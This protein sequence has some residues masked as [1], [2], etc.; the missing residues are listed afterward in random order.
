METIGKKRRVSGAAGVWIV[1]VLFF[2]IFSYL[3][4]KTCDDWLFT[5]RLTHAADYGGLFGA[6]K[7]EFDTWNGRVLGN[8]LSVLLSGSKLLRTLFKSLVYAAIFHAMGTLSG[9][10]RRG[11]LGW[12]CVFLC[13]FLVPAELRNQTYA[14]DAGFINYAGSMA[15]ILCYLLLMQ[16]LFAGNRVRDSVWTMAA[17]LALGAASALFVE[18]VTA[19]A[20]VLGCGAAVWHWVRFRR[21]SF[22]TVCFLLGALAGTALMLSSP[23][24]AAAKH[25]AENAY[26]ALPTDLPTLLARLKTNYQAFSCYSLGAYLF[27]HLILSG[28]SLWLL[29]RAD[30][31]VCVIGKRLKRA[32]SVLLCV[33]P[34][35]FHLIAREFDYL[36]MRSEAFDT[37][38]RIAGSFY[39]IMA[40]DLLLYGLY[41]LS[42]AVVFLFFVPDSS[43]KRLGLLCVVSAVTVGGPM[44]FV[45]PTDYRCFFPSYLFWACAALLLIRATIVNFEE[46]REARFV[47]PVTA[48]VYAVM[49][50]V[51]AWN[52]TIYADCPKLEQARVNYL[53]QQMSIE[54]EIIVLPEFNCERSL[55]YPTV[56]LGSMFYYH[57]PNDIEMPFIPYADWKEEFSFG[58]SEEELA[59]YRAA[60]PNGS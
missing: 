19:Y 30:A 48:C 25:A 43:A 22:C 44:L 33:L 3:I 27:L 28:A 32:L 15:L 49:A 51:C 57:T 41:V 55:H 11:G 4:P 17:C 34:V 20:L 7:Y 46:K 47:L 60:H 35:Y 52:L 16:P 31:S 26:Y 40:L 24:Y 21:I 14:W 53:K 8:G 13:M 18:N 45:W 5:A 2:A 12:A 58:L 1:A 9:L 23:A 36:A 42:L 37:L 6:L 56:H 10:N 29:Q 54:A 38:V 59:K 50:L 39:P